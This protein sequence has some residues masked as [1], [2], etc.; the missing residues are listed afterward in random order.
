[1]PVLGLLAGALGEVDVDALDRDDERSRAREEL[2]RPEY[3]AARPPLWRRLL[4]RAV[5]EVLELVERAAGSVPGGRVGVLLA[6]LLLVGA[7]ALVLV[8]LRPG[9][10]GARGDAVFDGSAVLT[11]QQHRA[12]ADEAAAQGRYADAVRERMR[13]LVRELE[14]RGVLDDRPGRT[15]A[16]VA[17]DAG[18]LVPGVAVEL[19]RAATTFD[20]VCYGGRAAD[21]STYAVLVDCDQ[22]VTRARLVTA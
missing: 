3:Q 15:A 18:A 21:P 22:A 10:R 4:G 16:E 17:R 20:E 13:A 5:R 1:M 12:L 7:V 14:A 19:R 6:A 8:R 11:A 9:L 2:S